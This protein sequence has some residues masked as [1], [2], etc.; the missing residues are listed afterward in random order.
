MIE[1]AKYKT[2]F[3]QAD[4]PAADRRGGQRSPVSVHLVGVWQVDDFLCIPTPICFWKYASICKQIVDKGGSHRPGVAQVAHLHGRCPPAENAGARMFGVPGEV[5]GDIDTLCP[6]QVCRVPVGNIANVE[7]GVEGPG[8]ATTHL[9]IG[10]GADGDT[11]DAKL[12]AI[13]D[14]DQSSKYRGDGMVTE[15]G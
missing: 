2:L 3:R 9:I 8:Q 4:I 15:I 5:D 11:D 7:K 1:A 13:V 10:L 14:L 6:E 12:S